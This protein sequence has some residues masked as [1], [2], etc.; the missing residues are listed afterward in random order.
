ME[1]EKIKDAVE[2]I[3]IPAD[4][5]ER[6][7]HTDW[8]RKKNRRKRVIFTRVM[9]VAC[10]ALLLS[11]SVTDW[12][13]EKNSAPVW[14]VRAYAKGENGEG[15]T[16]LKKGQTVQ[17]Q[18]QE[19]QPWYTVEVDLPGQYHY[20]QEVITVGEN[21]IRVGDGSSSGI[22]NSETE[23]VKQETAD[24]KTNAAC[25]TIID[26]GGVQTDVIELVATQG[27]NGKC[28]I[29]YMSDGEVGSE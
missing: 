17:L 1:F 18:K 9:L 16:Y 14:K 4:V 10:M 25:I 21:C 3:T 22:Q 26:G 27:E 12:I 29:T 15:W 6:I 11:V 13:Y 24:D 2:Q 28:Y 8:E 19:N 20:T 5:E 7:R 23:S